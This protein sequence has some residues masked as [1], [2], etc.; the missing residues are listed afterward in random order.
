M[1]EIHFDPVD[2]LY[3]VDGRRVPSVTQLLQQAGLSPTYDGVNPEVLLH[4]RERGIHVEACCQL[5]SD[6]TLDETSVHPEAQPY[7]DAFKRAVHERTITNMRWQVVGYQ[8][9]DDVAGTTDLLCDIRGRASVV[10]VKATA[11]LDRSYR[12]QL[13]AYQRQHGGDRFRYVLHLQKKGTYAL[14]DCEA[15]E[16]REGADDEGTW[17][18]CVA[19]ARWRGLG[20]GKAR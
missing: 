15:E 19:L 8:P 13:T 1:S 12:I 4:A 16:R 17:L 5:W 11:K 7:L 20:N 14:L 18:A 6:G 10:D 3:T 9:E 2:H